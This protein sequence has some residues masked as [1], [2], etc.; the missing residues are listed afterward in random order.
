[1]SKNVLKCLVVDGGLSHWSKWSSCSGSCG[2]MERHR[3]CT[4]PKPAFG[5]RE[6]FKLPVQMRLCGTCAGIVVK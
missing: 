1:M 3:S 5:G 4:N 2:I 6:C